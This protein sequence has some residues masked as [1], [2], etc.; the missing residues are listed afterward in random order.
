MVVGAVVAGAVSASRL[1]PASS[2]SA[3][4]VTTELPGLSEPVPAPAAYTPPSTSSG[5]VVP[6]TAPLQRTAPGTVARPPSLVSTYAFTSV[7]GC[8]S[9]LPG[10]TTR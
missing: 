1:S 10:S 9:W 2:T 3:V 4:A 5:S 7:D 6:L 8:G